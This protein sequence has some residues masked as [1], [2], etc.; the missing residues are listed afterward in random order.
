MGFLTCD[1]LHPCYEADQPFP[2][3][4]FER[5]CRNMLIAQGIIRPD[6]APETLRSLVETLVEADQSVGCPPSA[7]EALQLRVAALEEEVAF[8]ERRR[9]GDRGLMQLL[10]GVLDHIDAGL[11]S[12][13]EEAK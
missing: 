13:E 3:T 2:M 12:A 5:Y 8:L 7:V 11:P 9:L 4:G 10:R 1:V 6:I